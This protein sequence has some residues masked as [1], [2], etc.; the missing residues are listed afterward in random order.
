M[1]SSWVGGVGEIKEGS[2]DDRR[3]KED[4]R[5]RERGECGRRR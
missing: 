1:S 4:D 3:Q 5:R 2:C